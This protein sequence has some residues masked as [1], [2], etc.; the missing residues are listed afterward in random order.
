MA[1]LDDGRI[2][3]ASRIKDD[4]VDGVRVRNKWLK[5][6]MLKGKRNR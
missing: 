6:D 5:P 4:K 3:H 2:V 1:T